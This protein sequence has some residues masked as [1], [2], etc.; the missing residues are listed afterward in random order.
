MMDNT[1]FRWFVYTIK[2]GLEDCL[3]TRRMAIE[4]NY[5]LEKLQHASKM[6]LRQGFL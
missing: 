6:A 1:C 2:Q 3:S 4:V 5:T